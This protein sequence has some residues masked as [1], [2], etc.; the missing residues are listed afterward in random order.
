MTR[1]DRHSGS[2][3]RGICAA[4]IG[5]VL[6]GLAG[7][8]LPLNALMIDSA[9]VN[10]GYSADTDKTTTDNLA[11]LVQGQTDQA[12]Q[13]NYNFNTTDSYSQLSKNFSLMEIADLAKRN[14]AVRFYYR[15]SATNSNPLLFRFTDTDGDLMFKRFSS[16]APSSVWKEISIPLGD[17]Q[18]AGGGNGTFD[19]SRL[20]QLEI[21]IERNEG[22]SGA[23]DIDKIEL[24]RSTAQASNSIL[25]DDFETG[26][27]KFGG[28][29]GT[30]TQDT[31]HRSL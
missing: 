19:L 29:I 21:A 30:F 24:V 12:I 4:V 16:I 3:R 14:V 31:P 20:K 1:M 7:F 10:I 23:L 11:L 17:F 5:C 18:V 9:D 22:G 13:L 25:L 8:A 27:N 15:L 26:A 6:S 28:P 2:Y